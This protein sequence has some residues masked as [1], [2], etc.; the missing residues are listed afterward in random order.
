MPANLPQG[1]AAGKQ[2]L[3]YPD[4]AWRDYVQDARLRQVVAMG[5]EQQPRS[6]RGDRQYRLGARAVR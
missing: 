3:S 2:A 4:V 1:E 6:A 5:A